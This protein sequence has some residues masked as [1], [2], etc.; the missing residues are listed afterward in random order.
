MKALVVYGTK[1]G[2]TAGIAEKIGEKL[3]GMGLAAEVAAAEKAGRPVDYDLVI[4]GSGVRAG[5]WHGAARTWV[6]ENAETLKSIPVAFYTCGLTMTDAS[7]ADEVRAYT[8][9]MIEAT[10][11]TPIDVG[12][13]AGWNE[14]KEFSLLERTVLKV[15]KAPE[16]DFRDF[17]AVAAWTEGVVPRHMRPDS[18]SPREESR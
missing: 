16:G 15:M 5:N 10:G 1:S 2:C 18:E 11:V 3:N 9:S 17:T 13:F 14:P 7:K 8:D 6:S 4:V 12:L